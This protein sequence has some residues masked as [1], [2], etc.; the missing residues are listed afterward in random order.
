MNLR[1]MAASII[2]LAFAGPVSAKN[3][4]HTQVQ[5]QPTCLGGGPSAP[6][7]AASSAVPGSCC[8]PAVACPQ[9]L[10]TTVIPKARPIYRT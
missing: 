3:V 8:E 4:P 2:V 1:G 6:Q 5:P 9:Y 7:I 10:S